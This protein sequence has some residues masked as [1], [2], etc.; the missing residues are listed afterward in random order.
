LNGSQSNTDEEKQRVAINCRRGQKT[1]LDHFSRKALPS[2]ILVTGFGAFPGARQNPTALLIPKLSRH[3]ERLA[4]LGIELQC[5]VLPVHY[6]KAASKLQ[7]LDEA[8][9]SDAILHFGLAAR[10]KFLSIETRALNRLSL[11]HC[12]ARGARAPSR[13]II[14]GAPFALRTTFPSREIAAAL[15]RAGLRSR[16]SINAGDY[17][18]NE[19]LY[20]SLAH[21]R[22][23]VIGFIHVPRPRRASLRKKPVGRIRPRA[24][25]LVRAALI[26]ILLS[27]QKLRQIS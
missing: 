22:A 1:R 19:T 8:L 23:R 24:D 7:E 3:R 20:L 25:D 6:A 12:D 11:L 9:R 2:N 27:A 4:R 5:A 21:A 14:A 13:A 15:R 17:I 26:A 10:R 18:C 16:L